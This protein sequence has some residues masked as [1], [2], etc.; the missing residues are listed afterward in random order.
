M[1]HGEPNG[2]QVRQ[3]GPTPPSQTLAIQP[4]ASGGPSVGAILQAGVEFLGLRG[5]GMRVRKSEPLVIEATYASWR[6][7]DLSMVEAC[8]DDHAEWLVHLPPGSWPISGSIAGREHI[9]QLLRD[10]ARDFEVLEYRPIKIAQLDSY[11]WCKPVLAGRKAVRFSRDTH[12]WSSRARIHYGHRATG[13]SYEATITNFW[14]IERDKVQI[15][16]AFHD[17]A[18]LRAF[19]EMVQRMSI[20]A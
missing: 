7:H 4:T 8:L 9:M 18:R 17:A 19:F 16:E 3:F 13:L 12:W 5:P 1:L 15:F 20:E 10:V 11:W 14:Q 6:A 2:R